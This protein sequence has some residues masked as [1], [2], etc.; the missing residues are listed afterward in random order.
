MHSHTHSYIHNAYVVAFKYLGF[1]TFW[2]DDKDDV[3]KFDFTNS[4]FITEHQVDN[5]IPKR[6]DC[7]YFV[8]R[9]KDPEKYNILPPENVIELAVA[10]RDMYG[11]NLPDNDIIDARLIAPDGIKG[12]IFLVYQ[13]YKNI[14]YYNCSSYYAVSIGM[15]SDEIIN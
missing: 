1:D 13:N 11:N 4:L 6:D 15:L 5:H 12:R 2:F 14:L 10:F 7:L 8:H 9:I 3:S